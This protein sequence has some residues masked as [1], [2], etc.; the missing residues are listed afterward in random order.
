MTKTCRKC[1]ED[2]SIEEFSYKKDSGDK[3][4]PHCKECK[5]KE[6]RENYLRNPEPKKKSAREYYRQVVQNKTA[7]LI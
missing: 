4:S 7:V 3:L 6:S 2:K 1:Q 5:R